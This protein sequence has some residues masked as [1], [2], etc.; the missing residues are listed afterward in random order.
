MPE[1]VSREERIAAIQ[2]LVNDAEDRFQQGYSSVGEWFERH[3]PLYL[4][5]YCFTYFVCHPAGVNPE[6]NGSLDFYP[7]YLEI[8]QAFSLMQQRSLSTR[9]LGQE[10]DELLNLM[11]DIGQASSI[12][13]FKTVVN[14]DDDEGF[15]N[16][17]LLKMR[18][19][20]TAVR[21]P[22]YPHHVRHVV[23]GLAETIRE[24]FSMIHGIDPVQWVDALFSLGEVAAARLNEHLKLVANAY[25]EQSYQKVASSYVESFPDVLDFDAERLFNL[26][27]RNLDSFKAIVVFHSDLRLANLFVFTLDDVVEAYGQFADRQAIKSVMDML[28]YEFGDLRDYAKERVML[29]NP[30]WERPFIKIAD[31]AY[32]SVLVGHIP[33]YISSLLEGFIRVDPVLDRKYRDRKARYLEDEVERL[34]RDGFPKGKIYRG[35]MWDD[36]SGNKGENDLTMVLGSVAIV[37]E[38]KSGLL[39]P[40]AQRGAPERFAQRVKN[41]IIEPAEQ[42]R[43]FIQILEGTQGPRVF[44]TKSGSENT[45]D[46]SGVR[47]FLPLT[48][49]MEQ[50]GFLSN[51]RDLAE[52]GISDLQASELAQ[53]V[54]LTDLMVIFEIL[55]LQSEKV[56]YFFRRRELGARLKLHGYEMDILAFYLERGFNIG[57]T[58][59]S[60]DTMVNLIPA[61][62]LLDPY[63]VGQQLGVSV[64]K[65]GLSLTP[66]WTDILESLDEGRKQDWLDAALLLLNVP[67]DDQQK[68]ERRFVKLADRVRRGKAMKQHTCVELLTAPAQRKFC[69]ALYP[70]R[71]TELKVR[72]ATIADFLGQDNAQQSRG[73]VCVGVDIEHEE[74]PYSVVVLIEQPHLFDEI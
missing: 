26:A 63:F 23:H 9:P 60:G 47:Y 65:P 22:G 69:V 56:H 19:Q 1:S 67:F 53:V 7:H 64:A 21:N 46:V 30:V 57:E 20:T 32:F 68:L 2:S 50:F 59:F 62:T 16:Y 58:E 31:E 37:V 49:T 74:T 33:H 44:V 15:R 48:V 73:A 12:S 66:R 54:S 8:L 61:S 72:N 17:V 34:F 52:A 25:R 55:G 71:G 10:A 45:I 18:G 36:G 40:S 42:A 11:S 24:D 39:S 4:L 28:A 27:G 70:Y 13:E 14:Q 3:D 41:L 35:S 29:N 5:S 43:R 51:V 6:A 38:A